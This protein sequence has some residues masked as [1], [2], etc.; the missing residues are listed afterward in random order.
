MSNKAGQVWHGEAEAWGLWVPGQPVLQ[1]KTLSQLK[2]KCWRYHTSG[3]NSNILPSNRDPNSMELAYSRYTDQQSKYRG[4]RK[5][6][7]GQEHPLRKKPASSQWYWECWTDI[8]GRY[9][10]T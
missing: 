5:K 6:S 3:L 9:L 2:K 8:C 7:I 10:N 4:S 1:S